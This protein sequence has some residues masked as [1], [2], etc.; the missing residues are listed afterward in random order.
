[1]IALTRLV[2]GWASLAWAATWQLA[3]LA[4]LAWVGERLFR[5]RQ[6]HARHVL[7]WFVLLAPLVLAPGRLALERLHA[8]VVVAAPARAARLVW[9]S[10]SAPAASLAP[11]PDARPSAAA[12]TAP[13]PRPAWVTTLRLTDMLAL[14]WL[15]GCALMTLRLVTGHRRVRQ[16]LARSRPVEEAAALGV[17]GTLCAE[18]GTR[19]DLKLRTG[20]VGAAV[21]YGLHRPLILIP[22][23]WVTSL[24]PD[25]LRSLLAHEV[26]HVKRRDVLANLAQRLVEIPMFFHPLAWW[27]SRRITWA[28]EELC[29]AWA[30][31]RGADP[32]GY[33]RSLAAA[34]ERA[35][36]AVALVSLGVA[37]SRFTLFRRV[38]AIL[39]SRSMRRLSRPSAV[40]LVAMLAI[41]TAALA[42]VHVTNSGASRQGDKPAADQ[43]AHTQGAARSKAWAPNQWPLRQGGDSLL[44]GHYREAVAQ[45]REV[46]SRYPDDAHLVWR[47]HQVIMLGLIMLGEDR[48]AVEH[49]DT[50]L[51]R[52]AADTRPAPNRPLNLTLQSTVASC[53][54]TLYQ[55]RG[56]YQSAARAFQ[57]FIVA[58]Q[59]ATAPGEDQLAMRGALPARLG[60][61]YL[62]GGYWSLAK[63]QYELAL[64]FVRH[65]TP[66]A[67]ASERPNPPTEQYL[68]HR[69]PGLIELS[70]L[71]A[72]SPVAAEYARQVDSNVEIGDF[73]R[74]W[75]DNYRSEVDRVKARLAYQTALDYLKAHGVP[76]TMGQR[77]QER[78]RMLLDELPTRLQAIASSGARVTDPQTAL[79]PGRKV[80]AG[81]AS[82]TSGAGQP[83]APIP[84]E[85]A[86]A[87]G[88][89]DALQQE[90]AD[91]AWS[92]WQALSV[93]EQARIIL[94]YQNQQLPRPEVLAN[95]TDKQAREIMGRYERQGAQR[96]R[97]LQDSA[98]YLI[99]RDEQRAFEE[100]RQ[101][102]VGDIA[103]LGPEEAP[104][105]L[106]EMARDGSH[107]REA[108]EALGQMGPKA[109][110][111]LLDALKTA[112]P[113]YRADLMWALSLG[114]DPRVRSVFLHAL[115]DPD[116]NVRQHALAGLEGLGRVPQE[117]YLRCLQDADPRVRVSAVDGLM[118]VGDARAIPA[119]LVVAR[120]DV[121]T[122]K[123]G[124]FWVRRTARQALAQIAARTGTRVKLPP[125]KPLTGAKRGLRWTFEE[126]AD[127][128]RCKNAGIR[129]NAVSLLGGWFRERRTLELLQDVIHRDPDARVR[130]EARKA[131]QHIRASRGL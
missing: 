85:L 7:W 44:D 31:S 107:S 52:Y 87:W 129:Q 13:A 16:I 79:V 61:I 2:D 11:V 71:A 55:R 6:P 36:A 50:T 65:Y 95:L 62:C 131:I 111:P 20:P 14:A 33:A 72:S 128:A 10:P 9:E 38:E 73:H 96:R 24:P 80:A 26:A 81:S 67:P 83:A 102:I 93:V 99:T 130:A 101:A 63:Q 35:Y 77:A 110:P 70:E 17:L 92:R 123:S 100:R 40:A 75:A 53:R 84:P 78:Y 94:R 98:S 64:E 127:A 47:A 125:D 34:A 21:L 28:R 105:L 56:D 15:L 58:Q 108:R 37:E 57:S 90:R 18:A 41:S 5:L 43:S 23:V 12:A 113:R 76:A 124:G 109:T 121:E 45:A 112:H 60:D 91:L 46:L 4:L 122:D 120:Y 49:M 27:A 51:K 82:A 32:A 116:A 29:D 126:L 86:R 114:K 119:L 22:E 117:V 97:D 54:T 69:L 19:A 42:A 103:R 106:A 115:D 118:N 48:Q 25:E 30:I 88:R 39:G 68:A 66:K 8:T 89:L 1:M 104:A 59:R 74:R 3:V